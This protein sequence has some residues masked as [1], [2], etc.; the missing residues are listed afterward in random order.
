MEAW[1]PG[2]PATTLQRIK[3]RGRIRA[4][5]SLD[6]LN[7]EWRFSRNRKFQEYGRYALREDG[8]FAVDLENRLFAIKKKGKLLCGGSWVKAVLGTDTAKEGGKSW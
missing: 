7:G 5:A 8:I 4:K 6:F 3:L 2:S 1:A